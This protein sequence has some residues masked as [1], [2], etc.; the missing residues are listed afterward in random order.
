MRHITKAIFTLCLLFA[1]IASA[2]ALDDVTINPTFE[3]NYRPNG[4]DKTNWSKGPLLPDGNTSF[5]LR[6]NTNFFA[7]MEFEIPNFKQAKS[8]N[9]RL[10]RDAGVSNNPAVGIWFYPYTDALP[11]TSGT[12]NQANNFKNNVLATVGVSDFGS[13]AGTP[14]DPLFSSTISKEGTTFTFDEAKIA[15]ISSSVTYKADGTTA[16]VKFLLSTIISASQNTRYY[17]SN[18]ANGA[19]RPSLTVTYDA[20]VDPV[21]NITTGQGYA[22]LPAA[23]TAATSGD[24]LELNADQTIGSRIG[25]GSKSLTIQAAKDKTVVIKKNNGN[26]ITFLTDAANVI[27][28]SGEGKIILDGNNYSTAKNF[29][30]VGGGNL[31]LDGVTMRNCKSTG[32]GIIAVKSNRRLYLNNVTFE[33]NT[34]ADGS[35]VIYMLN[36]SASKGAHM[37]MSGN[38]TSDVTMIALQAALLAAPIDASDLTNTTPIAVSFITAPTEDYKMVA[39]CADASKFT[40]VNAGYD[41]V[42]NESNLWVTPKSFDL[43]VASFGWAS[44]YLDYPVA[45]PEGVTAYYASSAFSSSIALT[46]IEAGQVI[47]ANTGVIVKAA[48][49][50]TTFAYSGETAAEVSGN[51]FA[52]V[53]ESTSVEA[54]TVYVLSGESTTAKPIFGLYTG[55]TLGAN[56]AYLAADKV[57]A[58][59]KDMVEFTFDNE[60]T[61]IETID[62]TQLTI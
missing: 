9:L 31:T 32:A 61:G 22:D 49:G 39:G 48:E 14:I 3:A 43:N 1:G 51:L 33:N 55:T 45:V 18:E 28:K 6:W 36:E 23:I 47:P 50:V 62:N 54:N 37:T 17:S 30:E 7:I 24:V 58:S 57:P 46:A 29:W 59:A 2:L 34:I 4:G 19:N 12:S 20:T 11:T 35:G 27:I 52:G 10:V 21:T 8:L 16:I 42:E 41:V 60:P 26:N 44:M 56:K 13:T 40:I 53:T 5:E 15:A 38:N 25:F